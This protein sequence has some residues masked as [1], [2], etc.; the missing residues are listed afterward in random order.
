MTDISLPT[1]LLRMLAGGSAMNVVTS[2][3]IQADI[4]MVTL[5]HLMRLLLVLIA[6]PIL[7]ML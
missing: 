2:D 3:K 4:R 5:M 1:S 6:T 7:L